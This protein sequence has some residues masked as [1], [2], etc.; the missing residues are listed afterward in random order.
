M[1][2]WAPIPLP[3]LA[4]QLK[5]PWVFS[6]LLYKCLIQAKDFTLLPHYSP[7]LCVLNCC[8]DPS[9]WADTPVDLSTSRFHLF[10][11]CPGP[12]KHS[13]WHAEKTKGGA[14]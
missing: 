11:P 12:A 1:A 10:L 9:H 6:S 2:H 5:L 13:W 7:H 4:P 8:A 3:P 14:L